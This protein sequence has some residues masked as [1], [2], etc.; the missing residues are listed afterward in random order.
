MTYT[1]VVGIDGSAHGDAALLGARRGGSTRRR[2]G[3]RPVLV[4]TTVHGIPGAFD[5]AELEQS[6]LCRQ[7]PLPG[8]ARQ[9][10][11]RGTEGLGRPGTATARGERSRWRASAPFTPR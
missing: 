2:P 9:A 3:D 8:H 5:R 10:S 1:I 11:G 4:A 7:R 6:A